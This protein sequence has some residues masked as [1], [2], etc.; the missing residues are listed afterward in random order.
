MRRPV[1]VLV[2]YRP[3]KG[4]ERRF[5]SLLRRHWPTLHRAGL[6]TDATARAWRAADKRTGRPFFVEMFEWRDARASDAAH[7][8]PAG[9]S[10]WQPMEPLLETMEIATLAPVAVATPSAAAVPR[11]RR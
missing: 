2:T 8:D 9:L 6:V 1:P 11:R 7:R 3:R 4:A 5:L 10:V